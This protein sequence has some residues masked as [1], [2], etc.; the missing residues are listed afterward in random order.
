M[1]FRDADN[2]PSFWIVTT[3]GLSDLY[4]KSTEAAQLHSITPDQCRFDFIKDGIDYL[5]NVL[6]VQMQIVL[7]DAQN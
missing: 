5:F 6:V 1:S 2:D 3:P 4:A 7:C